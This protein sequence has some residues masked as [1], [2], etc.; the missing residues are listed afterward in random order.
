MKKI[1]LASASLFVFFFLALSPTEAVAIECCPNQY[2]YD[3]TNNRCFVSG[4]QGSVYIN[5]NC[6]TG[7]VCENNQCEEY[8]EPTA[9]TGCSSVSTGRLYCVTPAGGQGSIQIYCST[10]EECDDYKAKMSE[11]LSPKNTAPSSSKNEVFEGCNNEGSINTAIG[12][13]PINNTDEFIAFVLRW[14]IGVGGGVAFL[15]ILLAGFQIMTSSGNPDKLKAGQELMTSAIAGL[16]LL[17]FTVFILRIIGVDIL[18]LPG[19]GETP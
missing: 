7:Q 14:A 6:T 17:I 8:Q 10:N 13:I 9:P 4:P 5:S 19:F 12:C 1:L 15:L 2:Q 16:I 11:P 18:G 3:E